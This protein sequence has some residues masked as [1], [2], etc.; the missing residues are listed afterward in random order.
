MIKIEDAQTHA[1]TKN[2]FSAEHLAKKPT[3]TLDKSKELTI[4]EPI[5]RI[6]E[7]VDGAAVPN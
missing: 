4:L 2:V 3:N 6:P 1:A 5:A 7:R